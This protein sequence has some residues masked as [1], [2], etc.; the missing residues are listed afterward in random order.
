MIKRFSL[1]KI[2]K[3]FVIFLVVLLLQIFPGKKEY[4]LKDKQVFNEN[5]YHDIYLIDK[6]NYVSKTNIVI[7]SVE[8]EKL[9][10]ELT[11]SL[12]IDGKYTDRLPNGF[13][14]VLPSNT[15]I[16][17]VKIED[18]TVIIDFSNLFYETNKREEEQIIESLIYTL[19][20]IKKIN[21]INIKLDNKD[22]TKLPNSNKNID[23][24]L[25]REYGINK[26]TNIE[27]IKDI[28]SVT[29][30]YVSKFNNQNYYVP[31]T[32]YVN[33]DKNKINI[34][35]EELSSRMSYNSDLMSYL[36]SNTELIDF[37]ISES[38][39]DLNFN[40]FLF[41]NKEKKVVLEEV[42]YSISYSLEDT[43]N[44]QNV[45]FL[46]NNEEIKR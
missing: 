31:V 5:K 46:V 17:S 21:K 38:S 27:S 15:K 9:V 7:N 16:N 2:S 13:R 33:S 1:N 22:L 11:E 34:I 37:T 40:D 10:I 43:L 23:K 24:I 20:S 26:E 30:Y 19:T 32:K 12:I 39:I 4:T 29:I 28:K 18:D 25:T 41:D 42:I 45:T 44:I 6:N 3:L 36:N 35:I 8:L 14:A